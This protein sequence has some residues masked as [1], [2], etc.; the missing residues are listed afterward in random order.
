M[1]N[2]QI[3]VIVPVYNVEQYLSRCIDSILAQTFTNLELLLIDDGSKDKSGDICDEYAKK[4]DRIRVFHTKNGGVSMARNL[5]VDNARGEWINFIDSDDWVEPDLYSSIIHIIEENNIDLVCWNYFI[6]KDKQSRP[7]AY[8]DKNLSI[9][10]NDEII[11]LL[12][13]AIYGSYNK[14][15]HMPNYDMISSVNKIYK[16]ELLRTA[17]IRFNQ[18]LVRA[19]DALFNIMYLKKVS[20]I[21]ITNKCFYHYVMRD[22][23][24][25]HSQDKSL[26]FKLYQSLNAIKNNIDLK[27]PISIQCF[28]GRIVGYVNEYF[29]LYLCDPKM[30]LSEF[31]KHLSMISEMADTLPITLQY[32][33]VLKRYSRIMS[34]FIRHRFYNMQVLLLYMRHYI[35]YSISSMKLLR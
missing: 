32:H 2:P 6:D 23:S 20:H 3:S 35:K 22:S 21:A 1:N 7:V 17:G 4:D 10:S 16:T 30:S 28:F 27:D 19:E 25:M 31:K 12:R 8:I 24:V 14:Y 15:I 29:T 11:H 9:K 33:K 18:T 5:G 34:Y 13:K 26:F